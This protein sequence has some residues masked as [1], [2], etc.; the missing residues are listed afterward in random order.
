MSMR[1]VMKLRE[2]LRLRFA[3]SIRTRLL[4]S[5]VAIILVGLSALTL[6]AGR[7]IES[8]MRVDYERRLQDQVRLIARSMGDQLGGA[9]LDAATP[10]AIAGLLERYESQVDGRLE[11]YLP[12]DPPPQTG[13]LLSRQSRRPLPDLPEL[14]MA[15][16]GETVVVHRLDSEGQDT[17]YTA[18]QLE[19]QGRPITGL[20]QLAVPA[21][22]LQI[23]I[24]KSWGALALSFLLL[25]TISLA[26]VLWTARSIT[27]PL[28]ALRDSA[29]RLAQGDL[30][31]R[32]KITSRDEIA[33]VGQAF[34]NMA[35]QVQAM[36]DEQRAFASNIS[37]E[38]RTPLTALRLRTEAL[39]FETLDEA[40]ARRYLE[41]VDG[42]IV[43]LGNVVQDVTLLT[44]F[45]SGRGQLGQDEID[46]V[47]LAT[48]LCAQLEPLAQQGAVELTIS[49]SDQALLV[50]AGLTHLTV[51]LRNLLDNALKYTPAGGR[52]SCTLSKQDQA[53]EICIQDTG[54]GIA[55]EDLPH[56]YE[57][58]YRSEKAHSDDIPGTGLGLALVKS[59]VDAYGGQ[60]RVDSPGV[61]QGTR[62]TLWWPVGPCV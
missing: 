9:D 51:V 3:L 11:L 54:R 20:L 19:Y 45:D 47:R 58:F 5:N 21:Q 61:G 27:R 39:R 14:E 32:V 10:E 16:D 23:Q 59:I 37:H 29:L 1:P 26:A 55:P 41:E 60:I 6:F 13:A 36:L 43:R 44:R 18:A 38:L 48:V 53:I 12:G 8:A 4:L 17:L 25:T 57:R 34:N 42:E 49:G 30:S 22:N 40:T 28:L 31:H 46:V 35:A 15:L 52:V 56:I 24:L 2:A 50:Q 7:Q 33:E 62:V